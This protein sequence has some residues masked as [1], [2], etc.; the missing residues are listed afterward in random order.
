M[1][2]IIPSLLLIAFV[3]VTSVFAQTRETR[4]PGSFT[5]IAFRVPGKLYL[6]QGNTA[7]VEVEGKQE[8]LAEIE[9]SV[10]G[11]RLVIGKRGKWNNWTWKNEDRIN[12]YITMPTVEGLNV[13]GSGDLIAETRIHSENLELS[14][15]GSGSMK[16]EIEATGGAEASVS[17]SGGMVVKGTAKN[18]ESR[19]SGSGSVDADIQ[20]TSLADFSVSGSGRISVAGKANSVK[21]SI[22]GSGRVLA[23]NL[24]TNTCDVRISG[25]G[26]VEIN[27]KE[28]LNASIS[29]SGSVLY[30]G[31]P[32]Q[33]NSHSAGSGKVRKM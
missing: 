2:H 11:T 9:T 14:V 24:E 28:A 12:V 33:L 25:S 26:D 1:K 16:L 19:V 23:A 6:R 3:S 7:K 27:V 4:N 8:L 17:G 29:G 30:K 31:D 13:G 32:K 10:E 22:S 18:F 20:V 21:A 15:S 5:K